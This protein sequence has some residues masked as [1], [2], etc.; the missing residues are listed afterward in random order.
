MLPPHESWLRKLRTQ[1][2]F[3]VSGRVNR[4]FQEA[5]EVLDS[6]PLPFIDPELQQAEATCTRAAKDLVA[7]LLD[8]LFA[9]AP[10]GSEDLPEPEDAWVLRPGPYQQ[11]KA[12]LRLSNARHAFFR[13]Y[14]VL[15]R[16]LNRRLL[17]PGQTALPTTANGDDS[18][19]KA[20]ALTPPT[21][22]GPSVTG[23]GIPQDFAEWST[24]RPARDDPPQRPHFMVGSG[25]ASQ[26]R[27]F[28]DL[29]NALTPS[30]LGS[31]ISNVHRDGPVFVQQFERPWS[32]DSMVICARPNGPAIT[33]PGAV[34][35]ALH[36][37][38]G[39][40]D[41]GNGIT[42]VGLP[43]ATSCPDP[44]DRIVTEETDHIP[45]D[46][47]TWGA[48]QLIRADGSQPWRWEPIP[49]MDFNQTRN[50]ENWTNIF[51]APQ[52]RI[53]VVATFPWAG[54][55]SLEITQECRQALINALP[56]SPLA[57]VVTALSRRRRTDLPASAWAKGSNGNGLDKGNYVCAITVQDN[58]PALTGEVMLTTRDSTVVTC[59]EV[60]LEDTVAWGAALQTASGQQQSTRLSL[61]EVEEVLLSAWKTATEILPA[62]VLPAPS[63]PPWV[64]APTVELRITAE[65]HHEAT[66]P[67]LLLPDLLDLT[68]LGTTDRQHLDTLTVTIKAPP[69][70]SDTARRE[71][72]RRALDYMRQGFGF[73]DP[74]AA[75]G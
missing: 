62:A 68:P 22:D 69:Q 44:K 31:A 65:H 29:F 70:M 37:A 53:R 40:T 3:I 66:P 19:V 64:G 73:I 49:T 52:L 58:R 51:D 11:G 61:K 39:G 60:R 59:A 72:L 57:G 55:S 71:L 75:W 23:R 7:A 2:F 24:R 63:T 25:E 56:I 45:L 5:V 9:D 8:L 50:A 42:L 34:L 20:D 26:A 32:A 13:A 16:L 47:G 18:S 14:D 10:E 21:A 1:D 27:A 15:I 48:G 46:G 12:E 41:T 67:H 38:C 43:S 36:T 6:D 28:T 17:L 54:A 4:L 74:G 30:A 33:M 35:G